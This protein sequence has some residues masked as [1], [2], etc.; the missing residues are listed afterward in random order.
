MTGRGSS[1]PSR[2]RPR[3]AGGD[4]VL[5]LF[6]RALMAARRSLG[7]YPVGSEIASTWV[8]RLHRSLGEFFRQGLCFPPREWSA[9]PSSGL[10]RRCAP[11]TPR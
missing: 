9:T 1:T 2:P 3:G 6:L 5:G 8:R 10:A 11:S 4:R 7:L